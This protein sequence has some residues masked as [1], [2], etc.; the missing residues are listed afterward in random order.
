MSDVR[1]K[2]PQTEG[3]MGGLPSVPDAVINASPGDLV[4]VF[5]AIL[6]K[7][8]SVCRVVHGSLA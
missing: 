1:D 7:A 2:K 6:E 8:K 4:P 3:G 5:E